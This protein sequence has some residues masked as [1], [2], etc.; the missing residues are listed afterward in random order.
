MIKTL[1]DVHSCYRVQHNRQVT[2]EF[3]ANEFIEKLKRNPSW[4][5]KEME[6]EMMDKY[7]VKV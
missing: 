3:M 6:A 1:T 2:A 7:G 4:P 5:M